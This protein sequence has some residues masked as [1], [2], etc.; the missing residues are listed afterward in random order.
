MTAIHK[1]P[2]AEIWHS[3]LSHVLIIVLKVASL[4]TALALFGFWSWHRLVPIKQQPSGKRIVDLRFVAWGLVMCLAMVV[5]NAVK[6]SPAIGFH[7]IVDQD[8]W[9]AAATTMVVT[10]PF[11]LWAGRLWSYMLGVNPSDEAP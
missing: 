9:Y 2:E 3:S 8:F 11:S 10:F 7:K 4:P 6:A 5:A 1:G